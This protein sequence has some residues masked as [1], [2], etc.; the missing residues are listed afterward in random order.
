MENILDLPCDDRD[1]ENDPLLGDE[2]MLEN[3][4]RCQ[5]LARR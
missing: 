2:Q 4:L 1:P 3:E 5:D